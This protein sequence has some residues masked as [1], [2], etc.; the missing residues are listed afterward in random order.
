[1]DV[2]D[3][4]QRA[5]DVL[6][7]I[8]MFIAFFQK[9]NHFL[10]YHPFSKLEMQKV[11]VM[12]CHHFGGSLHLLPLVRSDSLAILCTG[13]RLRFKV[14]LLIPELTLQKRNIVFIS[15]LIYLE[16]LTTFTIDRST[17][18]RGRRIDD[19]RSVFQREQV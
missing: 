16:V 4:K 13:N 1:M 9:V 3:L 11:V 7:R 17:G 14:A 5:F 10:G 6:D 15:K 12:V 18:C 2:P 8:V 19:W